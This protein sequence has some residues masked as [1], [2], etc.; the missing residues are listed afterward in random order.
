MSVCIHNAY[1]IGVGRTSFYI[2]HYQ[3]RTVLACGYLVFC[4]LFINLENHAYNMA[5]RCPVTMRDF[6]YNTEGMKLKMFV[7]A[8]NCKV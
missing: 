2:N 8:G 5:C 7:I 1:G 6:V 4:T 3:A